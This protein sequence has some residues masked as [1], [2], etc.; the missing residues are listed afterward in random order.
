MKGN[1]ELHGD[2]GIKTKNLSIKNKAQNNSI[3]T[4]EKDFVRLKGSL[5]KEQLYYLPIK[6]KFLFHGDNFDKIIS[7]VES[8]VCLKSIH[9]LFKLTLPASNL[10]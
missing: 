10:L 6:T 3:I 7:L 5:P 1:W 9:S 8:I 2:Y 4:T